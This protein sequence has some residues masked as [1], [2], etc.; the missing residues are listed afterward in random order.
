M[1][2]YVEHPWLLRKVLTAVSNTRLYLPG[3]NIMTLEIC[4]LAYR[5]DV[6]SMSLMP[7]MCLLPLL[8]KVQLL[9]EDTHL[10]HPV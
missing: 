8:V 7:I 1:H 6:F 3:S 2:A 4:P 5:T 10:L 9:G